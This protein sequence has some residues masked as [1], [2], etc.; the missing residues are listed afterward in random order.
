MSGKRPMLGAWVG[1]VVVCGA[2]VAAA[3][4]DDEGFFIEGI[5]DPMS[6]RGR[7]GADRPEK[8]EEMVCQQAFTDALY[9]LSAFTRGLSFDFDLTDSA[10]PKHHIARVRFQAVGTLLPRT[11][12][13]RLLNSQVAVARI[14]YAAADVKR[15]KLRDGLN[16][17]PDYPVLGQYH[18]PAVRLPLALMHWYAVKD[19]YRTAVMVHLA[20]KYGNRPV[21]KVRGRVYPVE[22]TQA[23]L[24]PAPQPETPSPPEPGAAEP[25]GEP[26]PT[27][28]PKPEPVPE[29]EPVPEPGATEKPGPDAAPPGDATEGDEQSEPAPPPW[30]STKFVYHLQMLVRVQIDVDAIEFGEQPAPQPAPDTTPPEPGTDS[31]NTE[32]PDG[33]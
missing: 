19:C 16:E 3:A 12:E 18:D 22:F 14:T 23:E 31:Q 10:Q 30:D 24:V 11:K 32:A 20:K 21:L 5:A 7:P 6:L 15:L 17:L 27:T 33:S 1:L 4:A 28:S 29:S 9:H 25:G 8:F 2:A 13:Y 26:T